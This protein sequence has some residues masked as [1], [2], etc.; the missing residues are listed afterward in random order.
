MSSRKTSKKKSQHHDSKLIGEGS[1]GCVY[2]PPLQCHNKTTKKKRYQGYVGKVF[3]DK[4]DADEEQKIMRK[5]EKIDRQGTYTIPIV[6]R[7]KVKVRHSNNYKKLEECELFED[8]FR[9]RKFEP[10]YVQLISKYGG[11]NLKQF[12]RRNKNEY[13]LK[14]IGKKLLHVVTGL[15][16]LH[17]HNI[18][19]RDIKENNIV[20]ST[21][22]PRGNKSFIIDFGLMKPFKE[23][24]DIDELRVLEFDYPYYPPEF[25]VVANYLEYV[26]S[27]NGLSVVQDNAEAHRILSKKK[28]AS[29]KEDLDLIYEVLDLSPDDI[30]RK[31]DKFIT[32]FIKDSS[33]K[34]I[35]DKS[36]K[37]LKSL[38]STKKLN[39]RMW[40]VMSEYCDRVDVFSLGMIF[41]NV[42]Y[43]S[44]D[45]EQESESMENFKELIRNCINFNVSERY[46]ISQVEKH[47]RKIVKSRN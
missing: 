27:N 4:E 22:P 2:D 38:K 21:T 45:Y 31:I 8:E 20:L 1:Y 46:N 14:D 17:K 26:D 25:R 13:Y 41:L 29:Y 12:I 10:F 33:F 24:Y 30:E 32:H 44:I 15:K 40:K 23:V 36:L 37:S 39:N 9:R 6:D 7:C 5:I 3:T 19:H 18:C 42:L 43:H 35:N 16:Y 11:I 28:M 34:N 47:L